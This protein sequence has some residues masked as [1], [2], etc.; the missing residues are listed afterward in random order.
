MAP[1]L[2][3]IAMMPF[4]TLFFSSTLAQ[5]QPPATLMPKPTLFPAP[6]QINGTDS[7]VTGQEGSNNLQIVDNDSVFRYA[8]CWS[9]TVAVPPNVRALDGPY[10][11]M[12]GLMTVKPCLEYCGFA[13]NK[14]DPDKKGY[15][16]AGLELSR[17]CW[18]GDTLSNHSFQLVD[19][20]CDAPC[21]GANTTVCGGLSAITLYESS[22]RTPV[23]GGEDGNGTYGD[24]PIPPE[25]EAALQQAVGFGA[26]LML[27]VTFTFAWGFL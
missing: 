24:K 14:F 25:N 22:K 8:G 17:E 13:R 6:V 5:E 3:R 20:G 16:Y 12:P 15:R 18:C 27:A 23:C 10:L 21:D 26:V 1:S 11:V 9:E 4:A 2:L 19:S 7:L